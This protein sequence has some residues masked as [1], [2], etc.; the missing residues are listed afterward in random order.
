MKELITLLISTIEDQKYDTFKVKDT[1]E[2]EWNAQDNFTQSLEYSDY[3]IANL[4]KARLEKG[5]EWRKK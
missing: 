3:Q 2:K 4:Q 1:D 5:Y